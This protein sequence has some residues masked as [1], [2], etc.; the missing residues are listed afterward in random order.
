[1]RSNIK[2]MVLIIILYSIN[3]LG[4]SDNLNYNVTALWLFDEQVGFYPSHVLED[5]SD[6][7]FPL[8]LGRGGQIVEGKYRNALDPIKQE[9]IVLPPGE[10]EFGLKKMPIP[11]GRTVPPLTWE[12]AFYAGFMTSGER[13]LRKEVG[14]K[15]PTESKLNIGEFDW[16][17]DFW[18]YPY[19]K[20]GNPGVLFEIGTGP[21]GENNKITR[22][23]LSDDLKTFILFNESIQAEYK[24]GTV[25]DINS[26]CHVAFVYDS[27]MKNIEHYINGKSISVLN[28]VNIA[29]LDVGEED[30]MT[31]GRDGMFRNPLQGKIDELRFSEGIAFDS[32]FLPPQSSSP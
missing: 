30:Y 11:E 3:I 19:C 1:M 15:K 27:K 13:H 32:E 10:E 21:R 17:V 14:F 22:I 5:F 23:S 24:I 8:V 2:A 31:V 12:N 20:S 28:N 7:N 16:T 29:A 9:I 26:W 25:L 6:N 4:Q 18:F